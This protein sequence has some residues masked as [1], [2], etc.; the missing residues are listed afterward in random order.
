MRKICLIVDFTIKPGA[1]TRFLDIIREHAS[2]TLAHEG[3]CL[4]FDVCDPAEGENRVFLYEMYANDAAFETHKASPILA[5]TRAR[6]ADIIESRDIHICT[7]L[8]T[9][10]AEETG[11]ASR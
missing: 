3:G 10:E 11:G 1:K 5:R 7:V 4:Q 9:R 2:S 8:P 6:Y